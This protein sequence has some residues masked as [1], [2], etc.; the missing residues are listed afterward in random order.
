[1]S[2]ITQSFI[3][4]AVKYGKVDPT[5][6]KAVL[7]FFR[8]TLPSYGHKK[9]QAIVDE[10]F[11]ESVGTTGHAP[12]KLNK[13]TGIAQANV[14]RHTILSTGTPAIRLSSLRPL[15]TKRPRP[16]KLPRPRTISSTQA[17]RVAAHTR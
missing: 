12:E 10:L 3:N 4:V 2:S 11:Q 9:Q 14:A 5:S 17:K 8:V 6:R 16:K 7:K 15:N 1:M 13:K